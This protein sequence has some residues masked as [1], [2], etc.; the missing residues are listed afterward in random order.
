[1]GKINLLW[2]NKKHIF[3]GIKN[4]I[5]KKEHIEKIAAERMAICLSCPSIDKE[6]S[7]CLGPGL[8]PCCGLCGCTLA[9]KTRDLSSSCG[10]EE[11]PL[12]KAI[13]TDEENDEMKIKLNITD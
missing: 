9:F 11:T 12:W 7:K 6:G 5:F 8:Q 10:N 13:L 2:K 1:M 3:E 4:N